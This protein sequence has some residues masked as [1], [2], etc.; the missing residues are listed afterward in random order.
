VQGPHGALAKPNERNPARGYEVIDRS[1]REVVANHLEREARDECNPSAA[2]HEATQCEE[3][4]GPEGILRVDPRRPNQLRDCRQL[5]QFC[6]ATI[7]VLASL[8]SE[9]ISI[10][11]SFHAIS[12]S[13]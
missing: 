12:P 8:L 2:P 7:G 1:K 5:L 13:G 3:V 10:R 4:V 11:S 9:P 6:G